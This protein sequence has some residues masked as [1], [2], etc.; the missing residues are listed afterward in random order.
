MRNDV[1]LDTLITNIVVIDSV[2]GIFKA[3]IG[4]KDG[5]IHGVGKAGNPHTMDI[6][7][8]MVVGAG[9]DV[10]SGEGLIVTAGA[11]DVGT[12]FFQSKSSLL[13]ALGS[14]I[15]TVFGKFF[16]FN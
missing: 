15:T 7:V 3:D 14:G 2:S 12:S 4:I 8:G 9:T 13:S 6:T 5:M 1:A 10:I 11:I 16:S